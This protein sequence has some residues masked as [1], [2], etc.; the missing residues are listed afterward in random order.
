MSSDLSAGRCTGRGTTALILLEQHDAAAAPLER[1]L[2][3][4][5]V[6][7]PSVVP[8]NVVTMNSEV[9]YEDVDAQVRRR[10]RDEAV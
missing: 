1:E 2:G 10:R 8:G 9:E 3:R 4:A 5:L 7:Q 6:L